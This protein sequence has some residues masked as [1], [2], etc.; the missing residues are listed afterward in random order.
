MTQQQR[1]WADKL[2]DFLLGP[3][4]QS[5]PIYMAGAAA[6][7][8]GTAKEEREPRA[9]YEDSPHVALAAGGFGAYGA[10]GSSLEYE[11]GDR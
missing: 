8:S 10:A 9:R 11:N 6:G 7:F 2:V 1:S 3:A 5:H 4:P